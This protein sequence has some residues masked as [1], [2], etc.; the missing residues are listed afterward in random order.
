[1]LHNWSVDPWHIRIFFVTLDQLPK[2]LNCRTTGMPYDRDMKQKTL[3]GS[4]VNLF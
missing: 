4:W 3:M 2:H 1:M